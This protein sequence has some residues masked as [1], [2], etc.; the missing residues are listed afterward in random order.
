MNPDALADPARSKLTD[1]DAGATF[2]VLYRVLRA[3]MRLDSMT[4]RQKARRPA[5]RAITHRTPTNPR[6]Y[7]TKIR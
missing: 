3:A 1:E 5:S 7:R 4:Q 6:G 2:A